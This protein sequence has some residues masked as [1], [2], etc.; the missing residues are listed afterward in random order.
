[1][2]LSQTLAGATIRESSDY[3]T[4]GT[5]SSKFWCRTYGPSDYRTV[6]LESRHRS[7]YV[8]CVEILLFTQRK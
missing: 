4:F 3:R 8:V 7:E 5:E 1:M 2:L 6:G